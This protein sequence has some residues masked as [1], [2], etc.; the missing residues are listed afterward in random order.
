MPTTDFELQEPWF[1]LLAVTAFSCLPV[2]LAPLAKVAIT[3]DKKSRICKSPFR[4]IPGI[5]PVVAY[6][7]IHLGLYTTGLF[8]HIN[9]STP[10][11]DSYFL[12]V[13]VLVYT[14]GL[15]LAI[16]PHLYTLNWYDYSQHKENK[17]SKTWTIMSSLSSFLCPLLVFCVWCLMLVAI[18]LV[19]IDDRWTA[20]GLYLAYEVFITIGFIYFVLEALWC[21]NA[22]RK[23]VSQTGQTGEQVVEE[24]EEEANV[25]EGKGEVVDEEA[26]NVIPGQSKIYGR[27]RRRKG[28]SPYGGGRV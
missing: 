21:A 6:A 14:V 15:L 8:I 11:D 27:I 20:F 17:G 12:E 7:L 26:D 19:A 9:E 28:Y 18:I 5:F 1:H 24:M 22:Y 16:F 25:E 23:K 3:F 13:N 10:A 2:V 4:Y